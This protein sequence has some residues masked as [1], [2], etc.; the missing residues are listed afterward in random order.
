[1]AFCIS[2]AFGACSVLRRN[3]CH[4]G[5]K[6]AVLR[7]AFKI[8][9]RHLQIVLLRNCRSNDSGSILDRFGLEEAKALAK[10][11]GVEDNLQPRLDYLA[12]YACQDQDGHI[13]PKLTKCY[14]GADFAP[15]SFYFKMHRLLPDGT[16]KFWFDG[17]LIYHGPG[18]PADG[19]APAFSVEV[20][21][22]EGPHWSIHT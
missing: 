15:H 20:G 4:F 19:S 14:L 9:I 13:D 7:A 5:V 12:A 21:G 8:G 1:V 10:T 3:S 18:Q 16:Y 6:R 22:P 2:C 11:L 17:G